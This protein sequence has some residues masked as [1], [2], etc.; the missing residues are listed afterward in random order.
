MCLKF[1]KLVV[2]LLR[3]K[4]YNVILR[5]FF[6]TY[7]FLYLKKIH[8]NINLQWLFIVVVHTFTLHNCLVN[9]VKSVHDCFAMSKVIQQA[10]Y[11]IVFLQ[12]FK[13][14]KQNYKI[15]FSFFFCIYWSLTLIIQWQIY[16]CKT[17]IRVLKF[18]INHA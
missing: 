12:K 13:M 9:P 10:I 17:E 6:F 3:L 16:A 2:Y 7:L 11:L 1:W 15:L 4:I 8:N 14:K 5:L 18:D